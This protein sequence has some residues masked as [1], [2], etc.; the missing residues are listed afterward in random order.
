MCKERS[1]WFYQACSYIKDFNFKTLEKHPSYVRSCCNCTAAWQVFPRQC[2]YLVLLPVTDLIHYL[3][4]LLHPVEIQQAHKL[5]LPISPTSVFPCTCLVLLIR[6]QS[7]RKV[8][9]WT[10]SS[11][12]ASSFRT[13][14]KSDVRSVKNFLWSVNCILLVGLIIFSSQEWSYTVCRSVRT[15]RIA[16]VMGVRKELFTLRKLH[17]ISGQESVDTVCRSK[18]IARIAKLVY[19]RGVVGL[20]QDFFWQS[21]S[22]RAPRSLVQLLGWEGL[23]LVRLGCQGND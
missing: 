17:L 3:T 6:R 4:F 13:N 7:R 2:F 11:R 8:I 10:T 1:V 16:K 22:A 15:V 9:W 12:L 23:Q 18:E 14:R 20:L 19:L 21:S 5:H